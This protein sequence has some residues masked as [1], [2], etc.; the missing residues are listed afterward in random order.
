MKPRRRAASQQAFFWVI[1]QLIAIDL[2][3]SLNSIITAIGMV[4][5]IEIM[6]AAVVIA[7]I[8]MYVGVGTG[9]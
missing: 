7:M 5:Q 8:V 9:H 6:I 3:F 4:E 2:V 1:M